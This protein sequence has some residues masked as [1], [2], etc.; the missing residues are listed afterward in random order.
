[1]GDNVTG[2]LAQEVKTV[3]QGEDGEF[4]YPLAD[5]SSRC[6]ANIDLLCYVMV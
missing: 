6:N 5:K 1:M 2:D 3:I 4:Y